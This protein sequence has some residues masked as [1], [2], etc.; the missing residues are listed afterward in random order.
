MRCAWRMERCVARE[1]VWAKW[2]GR[3]DGVR[4]G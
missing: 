1:E 4:E 3:G 2:G